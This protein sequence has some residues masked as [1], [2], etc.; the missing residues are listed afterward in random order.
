MSLLATIT[1]GKI[2]KPP[3]LLV[4]GIEG[5]GKTTFAANAPK[6][7]FIQT[8]DGADYLDVAKFPLV[9]KLDQ[10]LQYLDALICEAHDYQTCV[11][12]SVDWLEDRIFEKVCADYNVRN[13]A[14]ANGGYGRGYDAA[15]EYWKIIKGKLHTLREQRGMAIVM[16]AHHQ[17]KEAGDPEYPDYDKYEP[18]LHAKAMHLLS[19]WSDAV[20]FATRKMRVGE[21]GKAAP[22]GRDGGERVLRC[23]GSPTCIAKSRYQLP[24]EMPLDWDAFMAEY[25]RCVSTGA[26]TPGEPAEPTENQ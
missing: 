1:T 4:Y 16:L 6:P 5:I 21:N 24:A 8:E 10:A 11:I 22:I 2:V 9:E 25:S 12:D 3:R 15:K 13:I 20:L 17:V 19:E 14:S 26:V 7:I 18:R 23:V